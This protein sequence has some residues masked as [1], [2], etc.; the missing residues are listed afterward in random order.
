[1]ACRTK[2]RKEARMRWH[3]PPSPPPYPV[4]N[5]PFPRPGFRVFSRRL[6][7]RV[8]AHI[9]RPALPSPPHPTPPPFNPPAVR[10]G[11]TKRD[12]NEIRPSV[13]KTMS[14]VGRARTVIRGFVHVR[15]KWADIVPY[16]VKLLLKHCCKVVSWVQLVGKHSSFLFANFHEAPPPPHPTP[17]LSSPLF[18]LTLLFLLALFSNPL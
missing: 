13:S 12:D 5:I 6:R 1:M 18:L 9:A 2:W 14:G 3:P 15:R 11:V 4:R 10:R 16:H 7:F 8:N 17:C